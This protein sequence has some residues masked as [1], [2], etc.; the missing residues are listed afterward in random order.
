MKDSNCL[1]GKIHIPWVT[2]LYSFWNTE[3]ASPSLGSS[4]RKCLWNV[5]AEVQKL[6]SKELLWQW[7]NLNEI[8]YHFL[9]WVRY[10]IYIEAYP[11]DGLWIFFYFDVNMHLRKE[12]ETTVHSWVKWLVCFG[13]DQQIRSHIKKVCSQTSGRSTEFFLWSERNTVFGWTN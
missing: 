1:T 10:P 12:N 5:F 6:H 13:N 9:Q 8:K 2:I 11:N 4:H 7:P 3:Q